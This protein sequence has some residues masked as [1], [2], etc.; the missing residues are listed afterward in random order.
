MNIYN[1]IIVDDSEIDRLSLL[2]F[3]KKFPAFRVVGTFASPQKALTVVNEIEVDVLFLD[4]Q[5]PGLNGLE[6]RKMAENVPV[7]VFISYS[8]DFALK[9]YE[10][11]TLDYIVKPLR[12]DRFSLTVKRIEEFM[13]VHR[14]AII[15]DS[16]SSSEEIFVKDGTQKVKVR[17]DDII[18]LE[19]LR[20]YTQIVTIHNEKHMVLQSI[21]NLLKDDSFQSFV[22]I[23]KSYAIRKKFV[24]KITRTEVLLNNG[25][26]LPLGRTYRDSFNQSV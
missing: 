17:L 3:L 10:L 9:S 11:K 23:H 24:H 18:Y 6:F 4:I 2:A 26:N 25:T 15:S 5:M 1:C 14:K 19:A 22:R 12:F 21:G 13:D 7:C 20:D 16:Y 8:P